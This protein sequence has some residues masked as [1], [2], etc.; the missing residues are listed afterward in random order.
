MATWIHRILALG[1]MGAYIAAVWRGW[2]GLEAIDH[3]QPWSKLVLVGGWFGFF[4]VMWGEEFGD[5]VLEQ[6][7]QVR[8]S[9]P[10]LLARPLGWPLFL[11][12]AIMCTLWYA[13]HAAA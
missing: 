1:V 13:M 10:D 8:S 4:M 12:P 9:Y 6:H 11:L 3:L 2:H 5:Y 7:C